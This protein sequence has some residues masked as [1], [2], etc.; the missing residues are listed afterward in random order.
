MPDF[1]SDTVTKP[2]PE[3]RRAMAE[4]EVGDDVFGEDP[5]VNRL[6]EVAAWRVRKEA[7]LFFPTGTMANQVAIKCCTEPGDEILLERRSHI[8]NYELAAFAVIS[9]VQAR[10]VEGER[11]IIR[12]PAL[13]RELRPKSYL[14][15]G[16]SLICLEDTTNMTGG[17][18]YPLAVLREI[19]AFATENGIPVHLDGARLFN[20]A[21][22]QKVEAFEIAREADS[23]MISLSK[24]LA[25]PAGS[26]LCGTVD[27]IEKARKWRKLLGGGMRQSGVLAAAGLVGLQTMVDRLAEDHEN[28]RVLAAGLAGTRFRCEVPETNI[29]IVDVRETG[30]SSD[31]IAVL[32][33]KAGIRCVAA[34]T[35][36]IR[37]VTHCDVDRAAAEQ[38][39]QA[40]A[41]LKL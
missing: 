4:A 28:A 30:R 7:G 38:A 35:A 32:L 27:F 20:A 14:F 25:A 16:P 22:A 34:D 1:R 33:E 31:Q 24:G 2:T 3:M 15:S 12:V 17:T 41:G 21:V 8:M 18:C 13:A 36:R 9:G 23:V 6:Q 26:V 40:L 5:T 19:R 37:L 11:G 29:V 10:A 39:A